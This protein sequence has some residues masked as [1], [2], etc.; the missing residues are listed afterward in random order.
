MR[1]S[2]GVSVFQLAANMGTS[3][4]MLE[5]FYGKKRN[6]GPEDGDRGDEEQKQGED[7]VSLGPWLNVTAF[8]PRVLPS[9]NFNRN[10]GR[11]SF[12]VLAANFYRP[13]FT[14]LP[15]HRRNRKI[16]PSTASCCSMPVLMASI[17][18]LMTL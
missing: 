9:K 12:A 5:D 15:R 1:I 14:S 2:E 8:T 3:V 10:I 16:T 17:A 4:E 18:D 6:A 7:H 11:D 13:R